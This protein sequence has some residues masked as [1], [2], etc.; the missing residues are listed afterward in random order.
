MK[1]ICGALLVACCLLVGAA[2]PALATTG[3]ADLSVTKVDS[4]DPVT[5]DSDLS[6]T[7]TVH[8]AGPDSS[9]GVQLSDPIPA[10]TTFASASVSQGTLAFNANTITA[11]FGTIASGNNATLTL[12]VHVLAGTA[13]G[14]V[15]GNAAAAWSTTT[16][17]PNTANNV[18]GAATLVA[19]ATVSA[20]LSVTKV[21]SPEPVTADRDR[22]S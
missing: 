22:T 15:I 20:N 21:N 19:A 3:S 10:N 5:A 1:G 13:P 12:T 6:Y 17:D 2:S 16:T 8:N 14:T 7:V 4:P 11:N 9:Q 18:A